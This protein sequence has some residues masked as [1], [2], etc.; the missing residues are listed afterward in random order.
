[1][2]E[3]AKPSLVGVEGSVRESGWNIMD[4][5]ERQSND[6]DPPQSSMSKGILL[7]DNPFIIKQHLTWQPS[8]NTPG[9]HSQDLQF[10]PKPTPSHIIQGPNRLP[11]L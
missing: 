9:T 3:S 10:P 2:N 11:C 4:L 7:E 6:N 5:F 8:L 1:M